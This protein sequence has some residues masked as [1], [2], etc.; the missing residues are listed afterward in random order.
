MMLMCKAKPEIDRERETLR[1]SGGWV[2]TG[3]GT[4]RGTRRR[5]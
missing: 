3:R 2:D 5:L 4:R 1:Q